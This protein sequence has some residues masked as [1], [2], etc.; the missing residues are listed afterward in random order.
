MGGEIYISGEVEL[1]INYVP[2]GGQIFWAEYEL[3]GQ[4]LKVV[5][6]GIEESFDFSEMPDGRAQ[7]I[8]PE[9]LPT[10]PIVSVEKKNG[11]LDITVIDFYKKEDADKYETSFNVDKFQEILGGFMDGQNNLD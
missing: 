4:V 2:Q 10:N 5:L 1:V 3:E 6:N 9:L 8:E 11:K 7:L